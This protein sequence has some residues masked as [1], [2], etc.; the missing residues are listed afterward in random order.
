[1]RARFRLRM[2]EAQRDETERRL[3]IARDETWTLRACLDEFDRIKAL[4]EQL[5]Q[6][7]RRARQEV[8]GCE[9]S[10]AAV[11]P[12]RVATAQRDLADAEAGLR[13]FPPVDPQ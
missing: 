12:A 11:L 13:N 9:E 3:A 1:M 8:V 5:E 7:F 4:G 6:R 10:L 2:L